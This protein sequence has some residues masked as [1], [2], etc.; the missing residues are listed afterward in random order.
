MWSSRSEDD[1]L[2]DGG[3]STIVRV[4]LVLVLVLFLVLL[5]NEFHVFQHGPV[6]D[7]DWTECSNPTDVGGFS[8]DQ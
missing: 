2:E 4:V 6:K 7:R 5:V 1:S 8:V 3:S